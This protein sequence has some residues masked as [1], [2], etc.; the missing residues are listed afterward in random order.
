MDDYWGKENCTEV[1]V[2]SLPD[3]IRDIH[4]DFFNVGCYIV[5]TNTFAETSRGEVFCRVGFK[6]EAVPTSARL[7]ASSSHDSQIEIWRIPALLAPEKSEDR[8]AEESGNVLI[9]GRGSEA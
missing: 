1:L 5:E 8:K 6:H 2:L 9:F 3:I 4:A 7:N